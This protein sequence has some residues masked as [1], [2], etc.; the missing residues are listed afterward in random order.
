MQYLSKLVSAASVT[1]LLFAISIPEAHA[2]G[3]TLRASQRRCERTAGRERLR[4]EFT[5]D[6]EERIRFKTSRF[7]FTRGHTLR[8]NRHVSKNRPA[9]DIRRIGSKNLERLRRHNRDGGRSRRMIQNKEEGA[10]SKC[11]NLEGTEKYLCIR[12]NWRGASRGE[13][14]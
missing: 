13:T 12:N 5:H 2:E 11:K 1:A 7:G 3:M 14:R 9:R 8:E 6:S 4:C 10:R